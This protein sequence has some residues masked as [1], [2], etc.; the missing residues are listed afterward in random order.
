MKFRK[1]ESEKRFTVT[2]FYAGLVYETYPVTVYTCPVCGEQIGFKRLDFHKYMG[3]RVTN[4]SDK[5]ASAI[6][7]VAGKKANEKYSFID[8]YCPGCSAA[9]RVYYSTWADGHDEGHILELVIEGK[10]PST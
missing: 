6:T 10:K 7:R 2:E 4:L 1:I 8:V 5:D 3:N 9:V